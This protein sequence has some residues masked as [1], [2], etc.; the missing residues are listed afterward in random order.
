VKGERSIKRVLVRVPNWIGDAVLSIPT[1]EY[2]KGVFPSASITILAKPWVSPI[3]LNN[4][5]VAE[6]REYTPHGFLDKVR[7]ARSLRKAGFDVAILFTNSF[8]SAVVPFLASIPIR[9]GYSTD[10]RGFLLTHPVK[11]SKVKRSEIGLR[12]QVFYYLGL[13][14]GLK[15]S[16]QW[17][18]V[19]DQEETLGADKIPIPH[20]YITDKERQWARDF[21]KSHLPTLHSPPSTFIIGISPGAMYGP[22]KRWPPERFAKLADRLAEDGA[23]VLVFGGEGEKD[24]CGVVS[25]R[26]VKPH[27]NLAGK[28]TLREFISLVENCS[29]FITNDSGSMHIASCLGVPTIAV[30]GST[31]PKLTGPLGDTSIVVKKDIECSPCFEKVCP[32][33]HYRCM[34]LVT[35]DDVYERVEKVQ[36]SRFKVQ[37]FNSSLTTAVFLDRDGTINEDVGYL[38]SPDRLVILEGV[39]EAIKRL[40]GIGL[41]VVVISNQS[42]VARGFFPEGVVEAIHQR[43]QEVLKK[44]G[45]SLDGFYYCP[46][47]PEDDCG[48]RKPRTGLLERASRDLGVELTASYM[49]GDKASDIELAYNTGAKAILVLT[50]K[51]YEERDK[52]IHQPHYIAKDLKEAVEWIIKDRNLA[53]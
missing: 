42:G 3:Y 49:V 13:L 26:M 41:K 50:G 9:V 43:L 8:E 47:H 46:H 14:E 29:V 27:L 4:P 35:V 45:A 12:H 34:E 31:D 11:R 2:I 15:G 10:M 16:G 38:D 6:V 44:D 22:A 39:P 52:L 19:G 40:N 23:M 18:V 7:F 53:T 51:G 17:S 20:I 1:I 36:G 25:Q 21:I 5:A 30:F 28:T 37:G 48:C 33:G 32:F 24:I